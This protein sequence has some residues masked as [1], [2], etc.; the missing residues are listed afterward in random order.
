MPYANK[1]DLY[2][3]QTSRWIKRKKDAIQYLGG[4]CEKCGYS[5]YYGAMHFH[6]VDPTTK[7]WSW[8]KLRLR[9]WSDVID[10]LNKCILLCANCHAETHNERPY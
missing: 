3:N 10:E 8:D 2:K 9:K 5:K 7:R 6:H 4:E 1:E